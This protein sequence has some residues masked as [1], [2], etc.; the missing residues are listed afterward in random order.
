MIPQSFRFLLP[1]VLAGVM[2]SPLTGAAATTPGPMQILRTTTDELLVVIY[3][4]PADG[5]SLT[6]RVQ[7]V[8]ERYFDFELLTRRAVGPGWRQL[9][10]G[11]QQRTTKL[12]TELIV[13]SYCAH[14]DTNVRSRVTYA[15]PVEVAAGRYELPTTVTHIGQNYAVTY[16]AEQMPDGWRFY[17]IIV[18][19][20]SL[21]AN[22][23]AQF[24]ALF[25]QGGADAIISA[26][27]KNL[28]ENAPV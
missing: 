15:T 1:T 7:P 10:P 5:R 8:M 21:V 2:F 14:F 16:R 26:L 12:L 11:Q 25:Q 18:E 13:R 23:R 22:Y 6:A 17:D 28:A 19:G 9:T 24:T 4:K 20:V 27:E 3:E